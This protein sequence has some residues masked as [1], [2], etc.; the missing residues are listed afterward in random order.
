MY[1]SPERNAEQLESTTN[2][3]KLNAVPTSVQ[4]HQVFKKL[5]EAFLKRLDE[6]KLHENAKGKWQKPKR[7]DA[8]KATLRSDWAE[9]RV[10]ESVYYIL[11][12]LGEYPQH[13]G[14]YEIHGLLE[15][16]LFEAWAEGFDDG[17]DQTKAELGGFYDD[18]L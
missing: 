15:E 5:L 10:K 2:D 18:W 12:F 17:A 9:L 11:W 7:L 1:S 13:P 4:S 8:F 6:K 14:N 3:V 16:L